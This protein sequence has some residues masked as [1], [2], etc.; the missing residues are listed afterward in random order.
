[1]LAVIAGYPIDLSI[2]QIAE[3]QE[4]LEGMHGTL[5]KENEHFHDGNWI[6]IQSA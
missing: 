3:V 6:E 1:M 5:T 4:E 2:R